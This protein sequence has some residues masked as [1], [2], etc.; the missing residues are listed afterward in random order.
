[1]SLTFFP[2]LL[3]ISLVWHGRID[4]PDTLGLIRACPH[5]GGAQAVV[6][7]ESLARETGCFYANPTRLSH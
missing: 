2:F 5:D 7:R 4:G 6:I 3:R 1:M